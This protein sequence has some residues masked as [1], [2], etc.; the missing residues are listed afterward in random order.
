M[1]KMAEQFGLAGRHWILKC[2]HSLWRS[3]PQS[4]IRLPYCLQSVVIGSSLPGTG[5]WYHFNNR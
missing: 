5:Y 2:N 4:F 3:V 1:E